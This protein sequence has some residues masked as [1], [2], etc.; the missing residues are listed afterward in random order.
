[1]SDDH[2]DDPEPVTERSPVDQAG[3]TVVVVTGGDAPRPA[4]VAEARD[5]ARGDLVVVAADS[6]AAHARAAGLPVHH[7]V[8]DL[9]SLDPSE[10]RHLE[11]DGTH[12]DRHPVDK[13]ATDL[14]LALGVAETLGARRVLV[15]GGDG[16]RLDHFMAN[17][18]VLCSPRFSNLV[19]DASM[20]DARLHV[21]RPWH[22]TTLHGRPG[23]LVT[24]LPVHGSAE[25]VTTEGLLYPLDRETLEAGTTRGVSNEM[26]A[27]EAVIRL[28]SGCLLVVRPGGAGTHLHDGLRTPR[29]GAS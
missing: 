16:G 12:V 20:G 22:P 26:S 29:Q 15:L 25:G 1:M 2:A 5:T 7:L 27:T 24:L 6:G 3:P 13:D 9:D 14:E 28:T 4:A 18:L 23:D 8:G 17:A 21:A 19:V 10:A 11:A